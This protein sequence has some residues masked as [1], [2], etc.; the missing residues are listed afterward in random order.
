MNRQQAGPENLAAFFEVPQV[1]DTVIETG[2]TAAIGIERIRIRRVSRIADLDD[3]S[4][5]KQV[6]GA[7][8]ARRHDAVEE[9]D[10]ATDCICNIERCPDTHEVARLVD[11]HSRR[12]VFEYA[13]SFVRGLPDREPADRV[14]VE[15]DFT[16]PAQ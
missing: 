1:G 10:A 4:R 8:M 11:R 13:D 15:A 16:K 7:C 9:I 12:Q 6:T 14:A 3:S 2:I 5:R